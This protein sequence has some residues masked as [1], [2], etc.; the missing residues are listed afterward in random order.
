[1][2]PFKSDPLKKNFTRTFFLALSFRHPTDATLPIIYRDTCNR[3]LYNKILCMYTSFNLIQSDKN[4]HTHNLLFNCV[5]LDHHH[6][7][8]YIFSSSQLSIAIGS[9][10]SWQ[11]TIHPKKGQ[12]TKKVI[13]DPMWS[14]LI[15]YFSLCT[16][17]NMM[18]SW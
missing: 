12:W 6:R 11:L 18:M 13:C 7:F 3:Y 4:I 14:D 9:S 1:M 8:V 16:E 10:S 5:T 17:I 2:N 15:S